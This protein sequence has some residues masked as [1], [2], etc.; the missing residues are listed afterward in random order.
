MTHYLWIGWQAF[1][2]V[3]TLL[4]LA[5]LFLKA[6]QDRRENAVARAREKDRRKNGWGGKF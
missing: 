4:M 3:F 1:T 5:G 6:M 2:S